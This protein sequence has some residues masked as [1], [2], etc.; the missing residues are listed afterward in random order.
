MTA[1]RSWRQSRRYY[2]TRRELERLSVRELNALGIVPAQ[3]PRLARA[4]AGL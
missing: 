4:A 1:I 2:V 3:I